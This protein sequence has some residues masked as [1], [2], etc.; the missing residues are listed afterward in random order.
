MQNNRSASF[1][2]H[3]PKQEAVIALLGATRLA[4]VHQHWL[5]QQVMG[6]GTGQ[7]Y[8]PGR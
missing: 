1:C 6:G 5:P 4:D 8:P 7:R 2:I 3:V